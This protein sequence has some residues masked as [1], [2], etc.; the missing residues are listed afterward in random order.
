M[1]NNLKESTTKSYL[2]DDTFKK[3]AKLSAKINKL[4]LA[5]KLNIKIKKFDVPIILIFCSLPYYL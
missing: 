1:L 3:S 4:K 2:R 5:I